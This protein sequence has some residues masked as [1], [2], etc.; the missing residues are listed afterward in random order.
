[1]HI[2]KAGEKDNGVKEIKKKGSKMSG[3]RDRE[4]ERGSEDWED[5]R[6]SSLSHTAD[7]AAY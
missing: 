5:E 6:L 2:E 4:R 1:M 7:V 3:R